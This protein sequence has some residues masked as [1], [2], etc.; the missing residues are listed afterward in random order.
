MDWDDRW[1]LMIRNLRSMA[2]TGAQFVVAGIGQDL[3]PKVQVFGVNSILD[4][5]TLFGLGC[6][7][8]FVT[9][10]AAPPGWSTPP[11]AAPVPPAAPPPPE[12]PEAWLDQE[13][14]A[15]WPPPPPQ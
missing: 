4:V 12:D 7:T 10:M 11:A 8:W 13:L 3:A 2:R 14:A 6:L 9:T 1:R 5:C 15:P